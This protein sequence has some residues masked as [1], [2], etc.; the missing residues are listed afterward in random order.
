MGGT[1][2]IVFILITFFGF[3]LAAPE[4]LLPGLADL[5]TNMLSEVSMPRSPFAYHSASLVPV[6]VV[7]AIYGIKRISYWSKKFSPKELTNLALIASFI[8]CYILA[9]LPLPGARNYWKPSHFLNLPDP[10]VYTIRSA[11]GSKV[12]VSAQ[13]NI[14]SH[15]SQRREIYC[16]PNKVGEVDAII[17]RLESPTTNINNIP[18]RLKKN[19]RYLLYM[20]D[21]H[22]KMD[23][24]EYIVSI[25]SLM[26]NSSYGI[27]LWNDPWLVMKRGELNKRPKQVREIEEKLKQLRK[28]WQI[29]SKEDLN[30]KKES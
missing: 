5:T 27:L 29:N 7:A 4:F 19:R 14:G 22:L 23:R 8:L 20:L 15:F 18:D 9:P 26:S 11:I 3:P 6:L 30:Y 16:Y 17:L 1:I 10:I 24:T 25:K 12:S 2:Y 21:S 13:S 28:E